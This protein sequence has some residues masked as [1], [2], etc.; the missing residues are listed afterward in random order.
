M[1]ISS[2]V[3][4]PLSPTL[5]KIIF[6]DVACVL[7]YSSPSGEEVALADGDRL[8]CHGITLVPEWVRL[9][10]V[11]RM[12][13]HVRLSIDVFSEVDRREAKRVL[14]QIVVAISSYLGYQVNGSKAY[15]TK[16]KQ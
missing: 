14:E 6:R 15:I 12:D 10:E 11:Q 4:S 5:I 8:L 9:I 7:N 16:C 13:G 2:A 1:R 3:P